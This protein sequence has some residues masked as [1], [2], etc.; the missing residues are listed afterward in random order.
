[1]REATLTAAVALDAI[2]EGILVQDD[3]DNVVYANRAAGELLGIDR[4]ALRGSS[5][6]P[7]P[8]KCLSDDGEALD[9]DGWPGPEARRTGRPQRPRVI[10]I[11]RPDGG[12]R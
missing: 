2:E 12:V 8:R 7:E 10:R 3:G 9:K 5:E 11:R 1:V 6:L 4:D